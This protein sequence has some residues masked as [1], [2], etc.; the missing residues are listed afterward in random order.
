MLDYVSY[1]SLNS[2][3]YYISYSTSLMGALMIDKMASTD[4]DKAKQA[5]MDIVCKADEGV[6]IDVYEKAGLYNPLSEDA[7]KYVFS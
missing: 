1:V 3:G 7:F 2:P 6:F 5:Y 4:F